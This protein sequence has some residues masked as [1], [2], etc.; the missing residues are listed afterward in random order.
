MAA[1]HLYDSGRMRIISLWLVL[2]LVACDRPGA[3]DPRAAA[4]NAL[5]G[6]LAYP[7]SR[8]VE[9]SAGAEAAQLTLTAPAPPVRVAEWYRTYLGLNGWELKNEGRMVD[10]AVSIYAQKDGRPLW[11]MLRPAAGGTQYT[12]TGAITDST[13]TTRSRTPP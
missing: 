13:L 4:A 10:S 6:V 3:P 11:I 1:R 9:M 5:G 7:H 2:L 8:V 12:L